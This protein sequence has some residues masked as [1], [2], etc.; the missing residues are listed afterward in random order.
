MKTL[1]SPLRLDNAANIYPASLTKH[2]S[3]LFRLKVSFTEDIDKDLLNKAL[4]AVAG[5]FPTALCRLKPGPFWWYLFPVETPPEVHPVAPLK[6]FDFRKYGN[7]IY[8]VCARGEDLVL[9]V[10][11]A[12]TDGSGGKTFILSIA[13]EYCRL[14]YGITPEYGGA[15]LNPN[16]P[17]TKDEIE[18]SFMSV[19]GGRK[20]QL[21]KDDKAY[22]IDGADVGRD[23]LMDCRIVMPA[24]RLKEV[25][26]K[27]GCTVT[28]LLTAA[29]LDS[30]Q[31]V[32]G[33]DWNPLKRNIIKVSVPVDLR[34]FYGSRS[35]RNFSTYINIGV[36]LQNKRYSFEGLLREVAIRKREGLKKENLEPKIAANVELEESIIV[37]AIP[38]FIK[39]RI[40]D[41]ICRA[42]GDKLVS[43]TLS[44][45][46]N[47]E[48][49]DS[50]AQYIT[51]VDFYLGRQRGTSG[52]ASCVTYRG[53]LY[54]N[55]TRKI[56][57]N[58]LEEY[59]VRLLGTL[60]IPCE[61]SEHTLA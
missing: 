46:C 8:R 21:E 1:E 41:S 56:R 30:L 18:D 26:H 7:H 60:D 53:K 35:I 47:I 38:L 34:P 10:F 40:I 2:Y 50:M 20:G 31:H 57:S 49:P 59:L 4:Q 13:A 25:C 3:S 51:G 16:D 48:L 6:A 19:F 32:H 39:K 58:R 44:N 42:H 23:G 17:F 28:E 43:Y 14:R 15:I 9:D 5:R 45:L 33:L 37:R 55:L 29:L 22:H 12:L 27:Y 11:H 52:A 54:L 36:D 61:V 24:D